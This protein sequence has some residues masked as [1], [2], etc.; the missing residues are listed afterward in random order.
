MVRVAEVLLG[1]AAIWLVTMAVG[2]IVAPQAEP[3]SRVWS[4]LGRLTRR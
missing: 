2:M 3:W 1:L 4:W